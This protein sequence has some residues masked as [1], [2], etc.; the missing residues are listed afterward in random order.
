[1]VK[2]SNNKLKELQQELNEINAYLLVSNISSTH[3][4]TLGML[5]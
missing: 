3:D 4:S 2:K 5:V 1:M